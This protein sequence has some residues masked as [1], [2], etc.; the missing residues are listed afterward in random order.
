[1]ASTR[2]IMLP[3]GSLLHVNLGA[4]LASRGLLS[5]SRAVNPDGTIVLS[6]A[7]WRKKLRAPTGKPTWSMTVPLGVSLFPPTDPLRDLRFDSCAVVGNSGGILSRPCGSE[8]DA[9]D[10][11]WRINGAPVRGYELFVGSKETVR[12]L[13]AAHPTYLHQLPRRMPPHWGKPPT[14]GTPVLIVA[15]ATSAE[16]ADHFI[17]ARQRY[18]A[19][20]SASPSAQQPLARLVLKD[21]SVL[22][23]Y[24]AL[25][26]DRRRAHRGQWRADYPSTGLLAVLLA[27]LSCKSVEM[28]GFSLHAGRDLNRY[29]AG[30]C[31]HVYHYWEQLGWRNLL[32]AH[33]L[34]V[35]A[36]IV[37]GLEQVGAIRCDPRRGASAGRG[38]TKRKRRR[39]N[40]SEAGGSA[41]VRG[42]TPAASA[43][44]VVRP[45]AGRSRAP[46]TGSRP[47]ASPDATG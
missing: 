10:A 23:Y 14:D 45:T 41:S 15:D 25:H 9:H 38:R 3:D 32:A 33:N 34:T 6:Q 29:A 22:H 13:N 44:T 17:R 30:A 18:A 40:P 19:A 43:S 28:Y 5:V 16:A 7:S 4:S 1:M 11:V 12:V 36:E 46:G 39:A 8:I 20:A 47:G 2:Q 24:L 42:K 37:R 35:E 27:T 21:H 26:A 31:E